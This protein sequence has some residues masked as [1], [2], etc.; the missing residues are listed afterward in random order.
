MQRVERI[1][2]REFL[3][4]NVKRC[5]AVLYVLGECHLAFRAFKLSIDE[6]RKS[7]S[8]KDFQNK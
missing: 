2:P 1:E 8:S 5:D 7:D 4:Q 6:T 3:S